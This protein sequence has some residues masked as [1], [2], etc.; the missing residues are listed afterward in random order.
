MTEARRRAPRPSSDLLPSLKPL[1][2]RDGASPLP[3]WSQVKTALQTMIVTEQLG[4]NARLPSESEL[5]DLFG[6]SRT[7]VREA[8]NQLV[9][10][11]VIYKLQGKGAF[12]AGKR[13]DQGFLG[14]NIGFSG[15]LHHTDHAISRTILRQELSKPTERA[16][17]ML[18]LAS[19]DEPVVALDRVLAVDGVPRILVHTFVV[20]RLAPGFEQVP[21]HNRSLYDT[22]ARRYGI[23]MRRAE[24]WLEAASAT[25]EQAKLLGI[26]KGA[27][28]IAIE[29]ISYMQT[30]E[31]IEYYTAVY[32]TDHARLHFIVS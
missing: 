26:P 5:C 23:T 3:L 18:N 21:M 10:E 31:A 4:E 17:E 16:R 2:S 27:P 32:R 30:D 20:S 12:V 28:V 29:S 25:A 6:V 7:V 19:P 9:Y 8:L 24:R 15:E 22:L 14:S 1:A 13:D 11:R